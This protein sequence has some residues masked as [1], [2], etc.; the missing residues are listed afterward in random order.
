MKLHILPDEKI[1]NRTINLFES[2]FPNQNK[3]IVLLWDSVVK[4]KYVENQ[5]K[6]VFFFKY[7][8]SEFW[9]EVGD[10]NN[11]ELVIVHYLSV[12]SARFINKINHPSIYW[13]EWGGDLYNTFLAFKGFKLYYDNKLIDLLC[14]NNIPRFFL[15]IYKYLKKK[16]LLRILYPAVF[17]IKYFVPDSMY[18]EY[19]LFLDYYP[20]FS[21]LKCKEFF[22]YP[23]DDI[24]G[25]ELINKRCV[26][27]SIVVG[28][29]ASFTG[30][31]LEILRILQELRVEQ[32]IVV[33]LSYSGNV[34]Y[35][36]IICSYGEE[37]FGE[38]FE[39]I[40]GFLT[41]DEYNKLLMS[42]GTFIYGSYRQEAVGNILIALY[43][44][45]K[46]YLNS[47]NPL[48]KFYKSL[49]IKIYNVDDLS[50]E[51][52]NSTMSDEDVEN[53]KRILMEKYSLN[54]NIALISNTFTKC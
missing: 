42:A 45:G 27:N 52:L 47:K 46:V 38:N 9:S 21:H 32:K 44:G 3:Y 4:T 12:L 34:E 19:P 24:L 43:I 30:N 53:N 7:N 18:D 49:G 11:Y 26:N 41:L 20:E 33:P 10:V 25:K 22:Y 51:N 23:I 1:I 40:K 15:R 16:R 54:Q 2:V 50:L 13:I 5:N 17:K 39:P 31:H 36:Q 29:S 14:Y 37:N 35:K 8:S 6:N 48:L 28:N